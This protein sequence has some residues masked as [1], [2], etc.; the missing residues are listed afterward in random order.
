MKIVITGCGGQL[1]NEIIHI[2]QNGT[3]E[4]NTIPQEYKHI[5]VIRTDSKLLD[6]TN[7]ELVRKYIYL[8]KPDIVI[9]TAAYTNVDGCEYNQ[10]LAFKVNS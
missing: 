6:I 10:D 3:S 7:L 2:L 1:G 4:L 8:V 5:D 9:N